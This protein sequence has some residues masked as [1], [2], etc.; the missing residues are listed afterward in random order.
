MFRENILK[1][2]LLKIISYYLANQAQISKKRHLSKFSANRQ[3]AT[4][5][6]SKDLFLQNNVLDRKVISCN[7]FNKFKHFPLYEFVEVHNFAKTYKIVDRVDKKE[8]KNLSQE[9][10]M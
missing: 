8:I 4:F 6:L 5:Y 9:Y 7:I 1:Y 2:S 3:L 10:V